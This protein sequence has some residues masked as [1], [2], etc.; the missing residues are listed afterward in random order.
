MLPTELLLKAFAALAHERQLQPWEIP[1]EVVI[2]FDAWSVSGGQLT[3]SLKPARVAL[4]KLY[5]EG[6]RAAEDR[7]RESSAEMAARVIALIQHHADQSRISDRPTWGTPDSMTP[8]SLDSITAMRLA[9][10][11]TLEF[12]VHVPAAVLLR[13][14]NAVEAAAQYVGAAAA[15]ARSLDPPDVDALMAMARPACEP[16]E[17]VDWVRECTLPEDISATS[18]APAKLCDQ[19]GA[20]KKYLLTGSTGFLGSFVLQELLDK[21]PVCVHECMGARVYVCMNV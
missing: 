16:V 12:G 10:A 21:L 8:A 11:L 4:K 3:P 5:S 17:Q 13:S 2:T 15:L 9:S 6:I 18:L 19:A 20:G 1:R 14:A 7:Q